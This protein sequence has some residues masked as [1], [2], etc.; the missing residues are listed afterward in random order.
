MNVDYAMFMRAAPPGKILK[1]E[2]GELGITQTEFARQIDLPPNRVSQIT[3]P[4]T[5]IAARS[6]LSPRGRG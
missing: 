4:L 2:L 1:E 6:D 5:R 3:P